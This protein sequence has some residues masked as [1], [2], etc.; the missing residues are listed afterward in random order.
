[1]NW[2]GL[3]EA[4]SWFRTDIQSYCNEE[5][6]A[7]LYQCGR[8]LCE[9]VS[10]SRA[11]KGKAIRIFITSCDEMTR[12]HPFWQDGP[13]LTLQKMYRAN[14]A[15]SID[16]LEIRRSSTATYRQVLCMCGTAHS[17]D[18]KFF[19][20]GATQA[21]RAKFNGTMASICAARSPEPGPNRLCLAFTCARCVRFQLVIEKLQI[22]R[23]AVV[24]HLKLNTV[25]ETCKRG[26]R[27]DLRASDS[28][29]AEME[30]EP[31][32]SRMMCGRCLA[33]A[34]H[35]AA[36]GNWSVTFCNRAPNPIHAEEAVRLAAIKG[37]R[38]IIEQERRASLARAWFLEQEFSRLQREETGIE[39]PPGRCNRNTAMDLDH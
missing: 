37:I 38:S 29:L 30:N 15:R 25:C 16:S 31:C 27:D 28:F 39:G 36:R 22:T 18:D 4:D 8:S 13:E 21:S 23:H 5:S 17:I 1:M 7:A 2:H 19:Q 35:E 11:A 10:L 14:S 6:L 26:S 33:H 24:I 32:C 20:Y 9:L 3:A 12:G 34:G